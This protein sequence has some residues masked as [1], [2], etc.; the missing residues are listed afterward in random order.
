MAI[1][2]LNPNGTP[3]MGFGAGGTMT[4]NVI[5]TPIER[6]Q[7]LA[8]AVTLQ[9][10][11][12]IVVSGS[13]T[14]G[15]AVRATIVRLNPSGTLDATFSPGGADGDG[16][17]Q[18]RLGEA[19]DV[20]VDKDGKIVSAGSWSP[21]GKTTT[22]S[23]V[24]RMNAD[25]S[26]DNTFGAD[27]TNDVVFDAGGN[28]GINRLALLPD[29][30]PIVAGATDGGGS[31]DQLVARLA[32]GQGIDTAF[33]N[34]GFRIYGFAAQDA[35]Q[36]VAIEPGGKIDV[37]GYGSVADNFT[38]VRLTAGGALDPSLNGRTVADADFGGNDEANA[39]ALQSNGK[40]VLGGST[41]TGFGVVRFQPGGT[42]DETFG[43]GGKREV[44]FTGT[45][46][47]ALA[48]ALQP[49]GKIVLAGYVGSGAASGA[50]VR[51]QGDSA[52]EGGGPG[53]G[54]TGGGGKSKVPRCGGKRA[55]I[56]GTNKK[57]K[58]KGTR[59]ADV[60]VGLGGDDKISGLGG[61]DIVCGGSG[62]DKISGGP[63][64]DKLYGNSGKDSLAGDAGNDRESGG[65]GNDKVSGGPGKDK[66][67]GD[68]GKDKLNGGTG[69]DKCAG[70]DR[71]TSC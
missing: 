10:D 38:L 37:A 25:G 50:V 71:K 40:I 3:D 54:G 9:P 15:S 33:G 45:L 60:I 26:D 19:Y 52:A 30:R 41:N 61:N 20:A 23:F 4:V 59:R 48:M 27:N 68:S 67:S 6:S 24:Q 44:K 66:L 35:A 62:N 70:K 8:D 1:T 56:V 57:N 65:S 49:D 14:N 22:D 36:D 11:G 7:D 64:N 17:V 21:F 32:Q 16:I 55:T 58:L 12:K 18:G 42:P 29:G 46:G 63:G 39:I 31:L 5:A 69:K 28:D 53:G 47:P 34:N 51:L 2:R 13:S 43:P